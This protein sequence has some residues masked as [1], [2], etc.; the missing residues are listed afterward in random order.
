MNKTWNQ[1]PTTPEHV[2]LFELGYRVK[3]DDTRKI[4]AVSPE[5]SQ[6]YSGYSVDE[7]WQHCDKHAYPEKYQA[8]LPPNDDSIGLVDMFQFIRNRTTTLNIAGYRVLMT[9]N[10]LYDVFDANNK[11]IGAY[12]FIGAIAKIMLLEGLDNVSG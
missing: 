12:G 10:D 8:E 6:V 1:M 5:G 7:A 11:L 2:S 9:D 3:R 4:F